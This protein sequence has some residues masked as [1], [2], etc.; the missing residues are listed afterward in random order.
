MNSRQFVR[1]QGLFE[2]LGLRDPYFE[3]WEKE[4]HPGLIRLAMLN[5]GITLTPAQIDQLFTAA[6]KEGGRTFLGGAVDAIK[7]ATGKISDAW[8][9]KFGGMLQNS[10][11]VQAFDAKYQDLVSKIAAKHPDIAAKVKSYQEWSKQNP[12]LQKFLLAIVGSIA[13]SLGIAAAGGV[14]AGALAVGAGAGIATGIVNIADRLLQ[15]QKASTAI[16]RGATTGAIA[17]IAAGSLRALQDSLAAV[18]TRVAQT[19]TII[20]G[21]PP[22]KIYLTPEDAAAYDRIM[23]PARKI[24]SQSVDEIMKGTGAEAA[25]TAWKESAKFLAS[26]ANTAYQNAAMAAAGTVP[27]PTA[28]QAAAGAASDLINQFNGAVSAIAGMKAGSA[29]EK[30]K[31]TTATPAAESLRPRQVR[32]IVEFGDKISTKDIKKKWQEMGE[33]DD[34]E[35]LAAVLSASGLNRDQ[36]NTAFTSIGV[37]PPKNLYPTKPDDVEAADDAPA[38]SGAS[39]IAQQSGGSTQEQKVARNIDEEID[40]LIRA[41]RKTDNILQPAYV[42]YFRDVLDKTFGPAEKSAPVPAAAD[43]GTGSGVALVAK[44][45]SRRQR[46]SYIRESAAQRLTLEFESYVMKQGL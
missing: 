30:A 16:G 9:N 29:G 7:G 19:N 6:Q 1:R 24:A 41:L 27:E 23:E 18:G 13:A 32:M 45:E 34:S 25:D 10:K 12:N 28:V 26:K 42:K 20:T 17:G 21:N 39:A 31:A 5:E 8:F 46:K 38:S 11:P 3:T 2:S 35:D 15:G 40:D 43:A 36:V 4:I 37:E 33:P 44:T 22:V 14:G